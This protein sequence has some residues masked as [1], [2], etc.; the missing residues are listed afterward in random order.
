MLLVVA[1]TQV[2][3]IF[4]N[5]GYPYSCMLHV[6]HITVNDDFN[7]SRCGQSVFVKQSI[8]FS[9]PPERSSS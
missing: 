9:M 8:Y 2:Y 3:Y 7:E 1:C 5:E 6:I 4:N